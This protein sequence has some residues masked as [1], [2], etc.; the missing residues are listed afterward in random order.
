MV[1]Q[2]LKHWRLNVRMGVMAKHI[3][4]SEITNCTKTLLFEVSQGALSNMPLLCFVL[5][6]GTLHCRVYSFLVL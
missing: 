3:L 5:S 1:G 6:G 2:E 4:M